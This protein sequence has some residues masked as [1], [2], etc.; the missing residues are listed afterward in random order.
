MVMPNL[1]PSVKRDLS[2]NRSF[3]DILSPTAKALE[4]L[5]VEALDYHVHNTKAVVLVE[6]NGVQEERVVLYNRT[7]LDL[8]SVLIDVPSNDLQWVLDHL[9]ENGWGVTEDDIGVDGDFYRVLP[10]S[11][12][13]N[14]GEELIGECDIENCRT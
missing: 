8:D 6:E 13:Y 11:L 9:N 1:R 12:G 5:S 14:L 2:K 3:Q 7:P 10:T 4:V